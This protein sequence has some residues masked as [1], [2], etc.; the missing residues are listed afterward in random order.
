ML[1]KWLKEHQNS[2]KKTKSILNIY[3]SDT[4]WMRYWISLS[5][6]LSP[7]AGSLIQ[8]TCISAWKRWPNTAKPKPRTPSRFWGWVWCCAKLWATKVPKSPVSTTFENE[9]SLKVCRLRDRDSLYIILTEKET[10]QP[11][12][13]WKTSRCYDEKEKAVAHPLVSPWG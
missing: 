12:A 4:S 5:K 9:R 3:Y 2:K 7:A 11:M 13:V 6:N 1:K 8:L 10:K